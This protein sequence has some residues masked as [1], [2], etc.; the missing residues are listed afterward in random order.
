V[1]RPAD[2]KDAGD[3]H[4]GLAAEAG[5][6]GGRA[7]DARERQGQDDQQGHQIVA[8]ALRDEQPERDEQDDQEADL[9]L[10]ECADHRNLFLHILGRPHQRGLLTS[11]P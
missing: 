7:E 10:G 1:K 9:R 2:H 6:G 3:H 8:D 5:E 4:R 11:I